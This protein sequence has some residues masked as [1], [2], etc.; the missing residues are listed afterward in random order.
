MYKLIIGNLVIITN[1]KYAPVIIAV[2]IRVINANFIFP[3]FLYLIVK[4]NKITIVD[5]IVG[6]I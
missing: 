5:I 2:F 1:P 3:I 6:L 4:Y